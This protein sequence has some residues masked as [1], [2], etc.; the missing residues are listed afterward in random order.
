M[1]QT[2]DGF[3]VH[4][5]A[6]DQVAGQ[7]GKVAGDLATVSSDY[8]DPLCYTLGDFGEFGMDQAWYAFDT[9]WSRE[10]QLT[11]DAMNELVRKVTASNANYRTADAIVAN[12]F[13]KAGQR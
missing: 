13:L 1:G 8:V 6:L 7:L 4:T 3:G 11:V 10:I 9:D 12:G 5:G 2:T